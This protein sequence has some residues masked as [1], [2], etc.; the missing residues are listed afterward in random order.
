MNPKEALRRIRERYSDPRNDQI[1]KLARETRNKLNDLS[2]NALSHV[3]VSLDKE[4]SDRLIPGAE[5]AEPLIAT[6][7][8]MASNGFI[9]R[10]S[11]ARGD[12]ETVFLL[13]GNDARLNSVAP[14]PKPRHMFDAIRSIPLKRHGVDNKEQKLQALAFGEKF[15]NTLLELRNRCPEA[16]FYR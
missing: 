6:I 3:V 14:N 1:N 12:A 10:C 8:Q 9:Y 16:F 15:A 2:G 4:E 13:I 11:L 5:D 7:S